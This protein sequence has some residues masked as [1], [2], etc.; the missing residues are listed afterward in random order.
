[1]QTQR[2]WKSIKSNPE[3]HTRFKEKRNARKARR[4]AFVRS[5]PELDEIRKQ[6]D[7]ERTRKYRARLKA[8]GNR[9]KQES[10]LSAEGKDASQEL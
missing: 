7:R 8:E 2:Y 1:M 9:K 10:G 6:K 4:K 5:H 3:L